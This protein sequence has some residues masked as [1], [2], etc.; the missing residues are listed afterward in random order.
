MRIDAHYPLIEP[1][2]ESIAA[3]TEQRYGEQRNTHFEACSVNL[4]D[5]I[6]NMLMVVSH[7]IRSPLVSMAAT[8]KLLIRGVYG[9][10]DESG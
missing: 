5:E 8:L 2:M 4:D 6:L 3:V 1:A 9:T 10:T 7:D